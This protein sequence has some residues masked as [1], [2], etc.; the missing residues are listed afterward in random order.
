MLGNGFGTIMGV[1]LANIIYYLYKFLYS[2]GDL[3]NVFMDFNKYI[4][5]VYNLKEFK[6]VVGIITSIGIGLLAVSFLVNMMDKVSAGDFS[7]GV[8]FRS[9]LKYVLIYML[10]LNA[11]PIFDGLLKI[12]TLTCSEIAKIFTP[13]NKEL[14]GMLD[15]IW[16][17]NGISKNVGFSAKLG[18]FMLLIIPFAIAQLFNIAMY[19]F[20]ASRALESVIRLTF[21]PIVMGVSGLVDGGNNDAIRYIKKTMG[22]FFQMVVV[23]IILTSM[24]IVQNTIVNHGTGEDGF[25]EDPGYAKMLKL[26]DEYRVMDIDGEQVIATNEEKLE[27]MDSTR[28]YTMSYTKES[29]YDF[30]YD[31]CDFKNLTVTTG[32]MIAA[33]LM[34]F[35]SRTISNNLFG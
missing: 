35:K 34:V 10:I 25:I 9:L 24:V 7:I 23:L 14:L 19:F 6:T 29:I 11:F 12:S 2:P 33:L 28:R 8:L 13:D 22:L 31:F 27:E 16:L 21:A 26:E 18:F 15:V 20:A 3:I 30:V 5:T 4:M 32:L 17:G 1:M